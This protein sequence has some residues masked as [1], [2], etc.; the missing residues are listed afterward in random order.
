MT[1]PKTAPPEW[2]T[3]AVATPGESRFVEVAGCPI[4]YLSWGDPKNPGLVFLPPGAGHAHWYDH[5]APLFADQ[6]HV[7]AIDP[8]GCGDSGRR[9]AYTSELITAEIMG[10]LADAGLLQAEI[11]PTLAGASAGAQFAVRAALA[12]GEALLGVIAID[13]LR[14]AR[15]EKDHA[16]KIL[17][18][19]RT[20]VQRTPRV[21]ESF[22][23][24]VGRFRLAPTPLIEIGNGFVVEHIARHSFRRVGSGWSSKYDPAQG[25]PI[26]LAFELKDALK[27]LRCEVAAIYSEHTHIADETAPA[28]ITA[29]TDGK[30]TT[31]RIPG[32]SHY[33][34][35]DSPFAFVAAVKGVALAW[36]ASARRVPLTRSP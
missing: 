7:V 25:A 21:Y 18:G 10:V 28:A 14:Y 11:P 2:F 34:M 32:T 6:F 19:P 35:I 12:H 1:E 30:A 13:G 4:H 22:E 33:P 16:I 26:T 3:R 15:L 5:V 20:A 24:A 27:D 8:S 23:A 31:F 36:V 29:A 9:E 17:E